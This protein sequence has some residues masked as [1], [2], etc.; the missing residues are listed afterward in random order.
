MKEKILELRK[1]GFNYNE[2]S[3]KLNCSKGTISYHCKKIVNNNDITKNNTKD[4]KI[5][6]KIKIKTKNIV[7]PET[8]ERHC[9]ICNEIFKTNIKSK[10]S[11][12]KECRRIFKKNYL[13]SRSYE[14]DNL[15]YWRI[16]NKKKSIEYKG[17]KCV[18][19]GYNKCSR[20]LDFHHLDP[21]E[22]DYNISRNKNKKFENM[23]PELDK[24][25]LVC[26]N[27]HGEIHEG[28]IQ[29]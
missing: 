10:T 3:K 18:V 28:I 5:I 11:C 2:I 25:V 26:K 20:S 9:V 17:G 12:S 27:C 15:K 6:E 22:K 14:Y 24:C 21:N 13:R 23:I 4:K 8:F 16:D 1:L 7:K 19:C 29:I